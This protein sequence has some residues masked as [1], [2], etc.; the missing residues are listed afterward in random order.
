MFVVPATGLYEFHYHCISS[1]NNYMSLA[2]VKGN[3]VVNGFNKIRNRVHTAYAS[4]AAVL[5]LTAGETVSVQSKYSYVYLVGSVNGVFCTFSGYMLRSTG[6][7]I[8]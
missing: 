5:Q 3:S 8:G 7:S 4:N 6:P 2:L 1:K